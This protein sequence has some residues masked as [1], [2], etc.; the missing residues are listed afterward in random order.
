MK[1]DDYFLSRIERSNYKN[2]YHLESFYL[3]MIEYLFDHYSLN[4]I[5]HYGNYDIDNYNNSYCNRIAYN[6]YSNRNIHIIWK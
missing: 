3:N 2:N 5:V 6:N 4:L 1:D